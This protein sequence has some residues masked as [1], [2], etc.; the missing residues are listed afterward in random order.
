MENKKC[1]LVYLLSSCEM[2]S[3]GYSGWLY[4]SVAYGNTDE[5]IYHDQLKNVKA[6]YGVDLSKDLKE[7]N[8][9]WSCYYPLAKNEL[10]LSVYGDSERLKVDMYYK[11]HNE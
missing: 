11:K 4:Y 9:F 1:W 8:G 2:G 5:E 7:C 3:E 6:I 10:P